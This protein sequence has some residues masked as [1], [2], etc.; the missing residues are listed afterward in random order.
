MPDLHFLK[1]LNAFLPELAPLGDLVN[2]ESDLH[3]TKMLFVN[4]QIDLSFK[5][6]GF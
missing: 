6:H 3:E 2:F 5:F 1:L 4:F